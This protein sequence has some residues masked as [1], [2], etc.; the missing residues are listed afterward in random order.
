MKWYL[1]KYRDNI[2]FTFYRYFIKVTFFASAF[3][4]RF[5]YLKRFGPKKVPYS[6][7]ESMS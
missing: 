6:G 3:V 2:I 4:V 7:C 1:V 5:I